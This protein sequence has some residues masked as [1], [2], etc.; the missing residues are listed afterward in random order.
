MPGE[1]KEPEVGVEGA[2]AAEATAEVT[3]DEGAMV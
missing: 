1:E 3:R 2:M